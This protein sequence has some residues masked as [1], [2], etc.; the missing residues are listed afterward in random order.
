M[1]W[2]VVEGSVTVTV[3]GTVLELIA[4]D[5]AI[6]PAGVPRQVRASSALRVVG[7]GA[8]NAVA[9]VPGEHS[10]EACPRGSVDRL[11]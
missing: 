11:V 5:T 7:C 1:L 2:S 4:G 6:L 9:S 3:D 10:L 8:G